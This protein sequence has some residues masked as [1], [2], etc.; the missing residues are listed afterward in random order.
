MV[1]FHDID[2]ILGLLETLLINYFDFQVSLL[3]IDEYRLVAGLY[4]SFGY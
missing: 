1:Q 2:A 3:R 4:L